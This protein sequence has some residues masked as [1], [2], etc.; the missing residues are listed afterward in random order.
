VDLKTATYGTSGLD[1]KTATCLVFDNNFRT[2]TVL[3]VRQVDEEVLHW[4]A[5]QD[6]A[7]GG[8]AAHPPMQHLRQGRVANKKPTQKSPPKKLEKNHIKNH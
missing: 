1:L 6:G 2:G 3:P 8:G 7:R 5:H 4:R